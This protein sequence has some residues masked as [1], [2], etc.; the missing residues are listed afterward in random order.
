[1]AAPR[2]SR[3]PLAA[4]ASQA[5]VAGSSLVLQLIALRQL[6]DRGLGQFALLFGILVTVN[7]IQSGW[8]G[9]SLTVLDRF[10][11][12]IR[13]ALVHSQVTIVVAVFSVTT[14]L[15][16][17]VGGVDA[18]TALLFGIASTAWVIEE[19]L[20]RLLIARREFTKLVVNDASFAFGS[21]G[22]IGFVTITGGTFE[23]ETLILALLA[24][25]SVAIAVG[26]IQL[27][28]S[29]LSR[30]L[31]G[32]SRMR[33][34]ARFAVWRAAQIGLRPGS[35]ALVRTVIVAVASYEALGQLESA[36]LLLAPVLTVVNGAGVLPAAHVLR[37]G[38]GGATILSGGAASDGRRRGDRRRSTAL[39]PP[40][41]ANR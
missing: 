28:S 39:S 9:D 35:Q 2:G 38:Q 5:I 18:T 24:G 22:L 19:T 6:G 16:L 30:G 21:F 37:S 3:R 27:P 10:D 11:P 8:L 36:R 14:V 7:S 31:L 1:M 13:R 41:S 32:P 26:V 40:C 17:P 20:R 34:V 15:A 25:A 29:E 23:L 33:D 4:V 12:G